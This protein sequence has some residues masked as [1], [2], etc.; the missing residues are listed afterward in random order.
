V[1]GI[2]QRLFDPKR[3]M[4]NKGTFNLGSVLIYSC[5]KAMIQVGVAVFFCINGFVSESLAQVG[6]AV[7][8]CI[9]VFTIVYLILSSYLYLAFTIVF[10][11]YQPFVQLYLFMSESW[12]PQWGSCIQVFLF[13]YI[14]EP[15]FLSFHNCLFDS[16]IYILLSQL[17]L[18]YINHWSF[19]SI[20]L[21]Y[22]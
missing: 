15:K 13:F 18:L 3:A 19:H 8:F 12:D 5:L 22:S 16:H 2:S 14:V 4:H 6:V 10:I 11:V 20:G 17:Y 21:A 1:S 9:N 7:F